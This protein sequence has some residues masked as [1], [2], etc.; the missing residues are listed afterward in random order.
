MKFKNLQPN[1][2]LILLYV[3][4]SIIPFVL[5]ISN[6]YFGRIAFWYDPARDFLLALQNL[7]KPT[8]IG[9]P[10]GLPGLFYGPY[11][12]WTISLWT[13][14]SKDPRIV[15]FLLL[16]IPYFTIFPF[17][18]YKISKKWGIFIFLSIWF[19]FILNFGSYA[20]QIWNVHYG[21]LFL[22]L[23]FYFLINPSEKNYKKNIDF[24]LLGVSAGL[25]ANFHLSFGI[26]LI[27]GVF[28]SIFV[29]HFTENQRKLLESYLTIAKK[30]ILYMLGVLITFTPFLLLLNQDIHFSEVNNL[31]VF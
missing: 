12:I 3:L 7:Q 23:T 31:Q 2:K 14:V 24:G 10:S 1:K 15:S 19:L 16:T 28:I 11:W 26:P 8:L 18:L 13:L 30:L 9:Q 27:A 25:L 22:L 6:I 21:A 17:I 4:V 5:T 20:N 29:I